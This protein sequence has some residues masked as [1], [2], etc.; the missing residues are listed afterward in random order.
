MTESTIERLLAL[1]NEVKPSDFSKITVVELADILEL[2]P[3]QARR[4]IQEAGFRL[5]KFYDPEVKRHKTYVRTD[6]A[7]VVIRRRFQNNA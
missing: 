6:D 3:P 4:L 1:K 5:W 7:E 2:S